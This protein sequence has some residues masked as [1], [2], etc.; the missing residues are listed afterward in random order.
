[1]IDTANSY[2]VMS[3]EAPQGYEHLVST[4][5]CHHAGYNSTDLGDVT[6]CSSACEE[7]CGTKNEGVLVGEEDLYHVVSGYVFNASDEPMENVSVFALDQGEDVIVETTTNNHGFYNLS[8]VPGVENGLNLFVAMTLS[9]HPLDCQDVFKEQQL[10]GNTQLNFTLDN[11]VDNTDFCQPEWEEGEWS[12]CRPY[13]GNG[14]TGEMVRT[15]TVTDLNACNTTQNKP[16]TFEL[17]ED[18]VTLANCGNG[19]LEDGEFCDVGSE[20]EDIFLLSNG[21]QSK[22]APTCKSYFGDEYKG[23]KLTCTDYCTYNYTQCQSTCGNYCDRVEECD[24][25]PDLC[26]GAPL[27]EQTCEGEAPIFLPV[28]ETS[29]FDFG[30]T[31]NV[32]D[33]YEQGVLPES[34]APGLQFFDQSGDVQLWWGFNNSCHQDVLSYEISYCQEHEDND[35]SCDGETRETETVPAGTHT[36]IL[37]DILKPETSFCF[38]ICSITVDGEEECAYEEGNLPCFESGKER[39]MKPHDPG[40]DCVDN[41]DGEYVPTGCLFREFT[42]SNGNTMQLTNHSF[43]VSDQDCDGKTC[44]ETVYDPDIDKLGA[45]CKNPLNCSGCNGVFGLFSQQEYS[46]EYENK[47]V[48]CTEFNEISPADYELMSASESLYT[49]ED[50]IGGLCYFDTSLTNH[51]YY[52]T[53]SGVSSCYDY[54]S[55]ETC[56]NDPCN[57]NNV[58]C[59]WSSYSQETGVGVCRPQNTTKHEC[60]RCDTDSPLGFCTETLCENNYGDC[61]YREPGANN[62]IEDT[63]EKNVFQKLL[64]NYNDREDDELVPTCIA[65]EDMSCALYDSKEDCIGNTSSQPQNVSVDVVYDNSSEIPLGLYGTNEKIESHDRFGFGGCVWSTEDDDEKYHGCHKN[66]DNYHPIKDGEIKY[67]DDCQSSPNQSICVQD[68]TAPNTTLL[69]REPPV[70][71]VYQNLPTYGIDEVEEISFSVK[72]DTYGA[73][74]SKTFFSILSK[75]DCQDVNG[76]NC[77]D[78]S[79]N[80]NYD[81]DDARTCREHNCTVYPTTTQQQ[82]SQDYKNNTIGYGVHKLL[83]Y[84]RD[85]AKNL[86]PVKEEEIFID[87][88]APGIIFDKTEDIQID[89]FKL[90]SLYRSNVSLAFKTEEEGH[91]KYDVTYTNQGVSTYLHGKEFERIGGGDDEPFQA[92]YTY[93][94]DGSYTFNI[95]CEDEYNNIETREVD[96][97]VEGDVSISQVQP[98]GEIYNASQVQDIVFSLETIDTAECR[99]DPEYDT[100]EQARYE[101]NSDD[102]ITHTKDFNTIIS[103]LQ[104]SSQ[105][106]TQATDLEGLYAYYTA[107]NYTNRTVTEGLPSDMISFSIDVTGPQST[108]L[109][110]DE[111]E[112]DYIPFKETGDNAT[113]RSQERPIRITCEDPGEIPYAVFGC[114]TINYCYSYNSSI[115]DMAE[116]TPDICIDDTMKQHHVTSQEPYYE[117]TLEHPND[118]GLTLYYYSVDK[119]GNVGTVHRANLKIAD[120]TFLDPTITIS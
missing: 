18:D 23:D 48:D 13:V 110:F 106:S 8:S 47:N 61:Y 45:V 115:R 112:N 92:Q 5:Y 71:D 31:R 102:S 109:Y 22:T 116:F 114:D 59:E 70:R 62:V 69:L 67:K 89:S 19:E 97:R 78:F 37:G 60:G 41:G 7:Y 117:I 1:C 52:R 80:N 58:N 14:F 68:T 56:S 17:C 57:I 63:L 79:Q 64:T 76:V 66:T 15:R 28:N 39:C 120:T 105:Q 51:D 11:C 87:S 50:N 104:P 77:Y 85:P 118:D 26:D 30:S 94:P 53:C 25:C 49:A 54:N 12:E 96:F 2:Q 119:G 90:N 42:F 65:I 98:Q 82:M 73:D 72:D 34:H 16:A 100:F 6:N 83:F 33:L 10:A 46:I 107:C 36:H 88:I 4:Q 111:N 84:T 38:N 93:V 101:F 81:D 74:D 35:N 108:L 3:F 99:F 91:C 44:V 20:Q 21:T 75:E 9:D 40:Y 86:E 95:E 55:K 113:P 24:D 27:C 32:F 43:D 29:N 103:S